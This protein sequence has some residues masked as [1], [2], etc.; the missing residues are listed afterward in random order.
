MFLLK[1]LHKTEVV[2]KKLDNKAAYSNY[3]A[4]LPLKTLNCYL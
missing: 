4:I 1:I 3:I 2:L